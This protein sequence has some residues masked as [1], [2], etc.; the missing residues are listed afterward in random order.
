MELNNSKEPP[1]VAPASPG[2]QAPPPQ[3]GAERPVHPIGELILRED[4]PHGAVGEQVDIAGY[5]GTILDVQ[6]HSVRVR[7][8]E[9]F[10]RSYN[11]N[12]L[13]K[14]YGPH[15]PP[16]PEPANDTPEPKPP[17]RL[18]PKREV[19]QEPNFGKSS[20]NGYGISA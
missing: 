17:P 16:E 15:T 4:F 7:S 9:G 3:P 14:L 20:H 5:T 8:A 10:T 11:I 12:V 2:S 6:K 19:V 1:A 13:R 18:E